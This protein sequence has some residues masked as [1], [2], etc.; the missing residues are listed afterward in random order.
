MSLSLCKVE[1]LLLDLDGVVHVG[2]A[3]LPG[4]LEAV[5]RLREAKLPFRF[6]TNTT[7]R[8]RRSVAARLAALGLVVAEEE[9]FTPASLMRDQ[10]ARAASRRCCSFIRICARISP[11]S[12]RAATRW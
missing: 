7:R 6:V 9:I 4:A 5:A 10:L 1:G 2:D 3:P 11:G 8:P 12:P